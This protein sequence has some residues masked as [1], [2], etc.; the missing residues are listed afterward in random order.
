M[1]NNSFKDNHISTM[2]NLGNANDFL[3]NKP[4][5]QEIK[6]STLFTNFV[7]KYSIPMIFSEDTEKYLY[8]FEEEALEYVFLGKDVPPELIKKL[9]D[10]MEE[11]KERN[12]RNGWDK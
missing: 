5:Q 4:T 10:T 8:D 1:F 9:E 12:K 7:I 3:N 11:R 6:E 2:K